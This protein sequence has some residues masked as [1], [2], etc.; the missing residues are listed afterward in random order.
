MC[1]LAN[2]AEISL[3]QSVIS[4]QPE[5]NLRGGV[6][7]PARPRDAQLDGD[8]QSCQNKL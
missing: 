8:N 5:R 1:V 7:G 2:Q 3:N 4:A 6:R